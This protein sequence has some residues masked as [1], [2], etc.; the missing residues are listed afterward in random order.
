[1]NGLFQTQSRGGDFLSG[2]LLWGH[3]T[4]HVSKEVSGMELFL[5][6]DKNGKR[7]IDSRRHWHRSLA[8]ARGD[9]LCAVAA[10]REYRAALPP[11]ATA[12]GEPVFPFVLKAGALDPVRPP[13][14]P[15][16][17]LDSL[18]AHVMAPLGYSAER[19]YL[20]GY[21]SFRSGGETDHDMEHWP[22]GLRAMI[23]RWVFKNS[24][25]LYCRHTALYTLGLLH[26][27]IKP[28]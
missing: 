10:M 8:V 19:Q 11:A 27:F 20:Y 14:T 12:A 18:R 15:Q 21:H 3:V 13:L 2:H 26:S 9:A 5:P 6:L 28:V 22:E 7:Y 24:Q 25:S 23:G 4:F 1:M 16:Q 17:F